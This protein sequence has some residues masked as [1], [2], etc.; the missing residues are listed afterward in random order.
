MSRRNNKIATQAETADPV[1]A[2]SEAAGS[3]SSSAP[4]R[5]TRGASAAPLGIKPAPTGAQK[6]APFD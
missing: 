1:S 2:L 5:A 3:I 6:G 4:I